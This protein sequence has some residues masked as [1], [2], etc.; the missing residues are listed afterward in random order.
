MSDYP[1]NYAFVSR[2]TLSIKEEDDSVKDY[3]VL[4]LDDTANEQYFKKVESFQKTLE[5]SRDKIT[6]SVYWTMST[7]FCDMAVS[8]IM[9]EE[10][11]DTIKSTGEHPTGPTVLGIK[12]LIEDVETPYCF[13]HYGEETDSKIENTYWK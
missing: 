11:I 7:A 9:K 8:D 13:L 4:V 12:V 6:G 10:F 2:K 1:I 3:V 5:A